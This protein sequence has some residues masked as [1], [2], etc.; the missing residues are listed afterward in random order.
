MG[1]QDRLLVAAAVAEAEAGALYAQNLA[2]I[3]GITDARVGPQL[4]RLE[5][6]GVLVRMPRTGGD[7]R[8]YYE[9]Q[10]DAFWAAITA[11]RDALVV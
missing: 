7:R 9:R 6:L 1:N 5:Q 3:A 11:L 4:V 2:A 10:N 8:V